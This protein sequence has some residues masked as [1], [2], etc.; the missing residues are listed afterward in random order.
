[1]SVAGELCGCIQSALPICSMLTSCDDKRNLAGRRTAWLRPF[2][3]TRAMVGTATSWNDTVIRLLAVVYQCR[4]T[5]CKLCA[6]Q[7][8]ADSGLWLGQGVG[9]AELCEVAHSHG[10]ELA[11][12]VVAFVLHHSGVKA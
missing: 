8:Q 6:R 3:K 7:M 2:M 1:M 5:C 9:E 12:E 11:P 10:V 4:M